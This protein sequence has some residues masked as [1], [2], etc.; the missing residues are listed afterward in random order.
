M[1]VSFHDAAGFYVSASDFAVSSIE[2]QGKVIFLENIPCKLTPYRA[3]WINLYPTFISFKV[4][5]YIM[6]F[7]I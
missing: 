7:Y 3:S 6:H 1:D 4:L 2:L 5:Y